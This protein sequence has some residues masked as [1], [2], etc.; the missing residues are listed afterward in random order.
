MNIDG[1][2]KFT[3]YTGLTPLKSCGQLS[4]VCVMATC[5][6]ELSYAGC[7]FARRAALS[8]WAVHFR[9]NQINIRKKGLGVILRNISF[10]FSYFLISSFFF[11]YI[12]WIFLEHLEIKSAAFF[13]RERQIRVERHV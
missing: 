3:K 13:R 6:S 12:F 7:S 11:H 8:C 9:V 5:A 10:E 4:F 2:F 1:K